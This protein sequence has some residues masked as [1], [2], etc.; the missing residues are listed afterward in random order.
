MR[1]RLI[2]KLTRPALV[3]LVIAT[4][5]PAAEID[6]LTGP[7]VLKSREAAGVAAACVLRN[8]G[9]TVL[10]FYHGIVAGDRF[11]TYINPLRC[12]S[13]PQYPFSIQKIDLTMYT[14]FGGVWPVQVAI[15]VW[16]PAGSDSCGGPSTLVCADT[17]MLDAAGFLLPSIGTVTLSRRCCVTGPY[18]LAI[19][20]TGG[21]SSPYPSVMFDSRMPGDSCINWGYAT[22]FGWSRWNHYWTSP[23]P[24]NLV[25]WVEGETSSAVCGN[26]G[27]CTGK[28]GNIDADPLEI[29]DISDLVALVGYLFQGGTISSCADEDNVDADPSGAVD[30]SD[31]QRLVDFLFFGVD[32]PNCP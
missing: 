15:E 6:V 27:C 7:Q 17:V 20:Y 18:Y 25:A 12:V 11:A 22:G 28:T 30:I 26:T 3:I 8:N 13:S 10:S 31:L 14:N 9:D 23:F 4:S 5:T 21:T 29:V 19:R 24:G 32:L 2:S 1:N 16:L